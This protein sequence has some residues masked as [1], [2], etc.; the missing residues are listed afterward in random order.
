MHRSSYFV[1]LAAGAMACGNTPKQDAT[2]VADAPAVIAAPLDLPQVKTADAGPKLS[3]DSPIPPDSMQRVNDVGVAYALIA[4]TMVRQDGYTLNQLY[5]PNATLKVPDST[6][7]GGA[8]IVRSLLKLGKSKGLSEFRRTS[9]LLQIA[10]DST[11]VDSGS[12]VMVTKRT[13]KD[14][15]IEQGTYATR[16][17]VRPRA[18]SWVVLEDA[19]SEAK[20]MSARPAK[21]KAK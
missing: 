8:N 16:W 3:P 20:P 14:S 2:P 6:I 5:A 18:G 7:T 15:T 17:R 11:L 10:D 21:K 19:I 9:A 13:E 1:L 4:A 12:Y